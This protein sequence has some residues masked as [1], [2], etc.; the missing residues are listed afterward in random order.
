MTAWVC[1]TDFLLANPAEMRSAQLTTHMVAP[2]NL[3]DRGGAIRTRP[4]FLT[5]PE[6]EIFERHTLRALVP[7][8]PALETHGEGAFAANSSLLAATRLLNNF[9]AVRSRTED[10]VLAA[11][12][13]E[14]LIRT[15][16]SCPQNRRQI[17]CLQVSDVVLECAAIL[18]AVDLRLL[19]RY[20]RL[21]VLDCAINAVAMLTLQRV[22]VLCVVCFAADIAHFCAFAHLSRD[23]GHFFT[24]E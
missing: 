10:H 22:E 8:V 17:Q 9:T 2:G 23:V 7:P 12:N 21:N 1:L 5:M 20:V 24:L 11:S 16:E 13:L 6:C 14:L 18:Q 19:A 3:F 4:E 15:F